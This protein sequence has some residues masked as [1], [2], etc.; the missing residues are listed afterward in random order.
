[1][2]DD[3]QFPEPPEAVRSEGARSQNAHAV[4]ADTDRAALAAEA[5]AKAKSDALARGGRPPGPVTANFSRKKG[6]GF[7]VAAG[8]QSGG[9]SVRGQAGS[10]PAGGRSGSG[11]VPGQA[12]SDPAGGRQAGRGRPRRD[13]PAP[14]NAAIGELV[15]DAGWDLAVAGRS[16]L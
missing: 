11:S 9:G 4:L 6:D 5:L 1:M 12:G 14:L 7:D 10:D 15:V 2:S 16:R 13:D 8:G 3:Q